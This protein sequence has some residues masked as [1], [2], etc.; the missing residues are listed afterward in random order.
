MALGKEPQRFIKGDAL[1]LHDEFQDVA[2]GAAAEALVELVSGMHGKRWSLFVVERA[3]ANKAGRA[4]TAQPRH[5]LLHHLY[6]VDRSF[7]LFDKFHVERET[8]SAIIA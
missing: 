7:Q 1:D 8:L 2:A 3:Q 6:D 4:R 5:V